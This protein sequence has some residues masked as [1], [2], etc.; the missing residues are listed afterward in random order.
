MSIVRQLCAQLNNFRNKHYFLKTY[1]FLG[2]NYKENKYKTLKKKRFK[3]VI[4]ADLTSLFYLP[5]LLIKMTKMLKFYG[6]D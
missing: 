3:I 2:N 1:T 6:N 5:F 4:L